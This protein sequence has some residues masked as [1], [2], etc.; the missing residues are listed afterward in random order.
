MNIEVNGNKIMVSAGLEVFFMEALMKS[1]IINSTDTPISDISVKIK[2]EPKTKVKDVG[3]DYIH[4]KIMPPIISGSVNKRVK[5]AFNPNIIG[6]QA[7]ILS[8]NCSSITQ[9]LNKIGLSGI[10][11][12]TALI[13]HYSVTTIA[14]NPWHRGKT[15]KPT[16]EPTAKHNG[17]I[18][19]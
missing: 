11:E 15:S 16:T 14:K 3:G 7:I 1:I 13:G 6:Q 12:E 8:H 19:I 4:N 2:P 5:L 18:F 10:L 17:L 9:A